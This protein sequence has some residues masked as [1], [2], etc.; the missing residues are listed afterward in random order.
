MGQTWQLVALV[1]MKVFNA[2]F[3][4][5]VLGGVAWRVASLVLGL[6]SPPSGNYCTMTPDPVFAHTLTLPVPH[7]RE[8]LVK[9]PL[10]LHALFVGAQGGDREHRE[11]SAEGERCTDAGAFFNKVKRWVVWRGG[12]WV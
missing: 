9:T 11:D 4:G 7:R 3:G 12:M 10:C 2:H 6:N 8:R 1:H 5:S